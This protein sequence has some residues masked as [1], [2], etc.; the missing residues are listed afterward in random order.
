MVG[1]PHQCHDEQDETQS[2]IMNGNDKYDQG[3]ENRPRNRL[4]RVKA[5]RGPCGW[6]AAFVVGAMR[7]FEPFG[8]MHP[9]VRPIKPSVMRE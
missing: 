8:D 2:I 7:Y 3:N 5:H 9:T 4:Y 1:D 6:W